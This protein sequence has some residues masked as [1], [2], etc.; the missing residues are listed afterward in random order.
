MKQSILFV[1]AILVTAFLGNAQELNTLTEAEK[2]AGWELLFNGHDLDGWK[3]FQGGEVKGWKVIDGILYNSG[4]G[5]DH[6]GDIITKKKYRDFE[7][8][9]EWK[10]APQSNSGVFYR[11]QEG[12]AD[13][14]YESGPEYQLLDDNGW[15][16]KLSDSQYSGSNYAMQKPIGAAIKPIDE[17]NATRIIVNGSKVEHY[18]NGKRVVEYE[19]WTEEWKERK[20]KCKWKDAPYYGIAKKGHI[21]LQ[22][23]G[24][25]TQFRNLKIRKL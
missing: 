13:K 15:P 14:I 1:A 9:L 19:L 17:W 25:L 11:V 7:L 12:V 8:Y 2:K 3:I 10:I 6:G 16:T 20:N 5:S 23:H 22:D 4:V 24:G 18:L 21:G